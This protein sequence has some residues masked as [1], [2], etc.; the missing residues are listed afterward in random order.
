VDY[1]AIIAL[2]KQCIMKLDTMMVDIMP[3]SIMKNLLI[4]EDSFY[5]IDIINS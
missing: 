1:A 4:T 5:T 3:Q 2:K